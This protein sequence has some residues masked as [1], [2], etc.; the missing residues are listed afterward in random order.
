MHRNP[1]PE[2][3]AITVPRDNS[4]KKPASIPSAMA[5]SCGLIPVSTAAAPLVLLT[6]FSAPAVVSSVGQ[7]K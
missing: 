5:A 3:S 7:Y 1:A 6:P 2:K 4:P